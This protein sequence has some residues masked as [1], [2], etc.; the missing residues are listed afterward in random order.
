MVNRRWPWIILSPLITSTIT[1]IFFYII[2]GNHLL[3]LLKT[4]ISYGFIAGLAGASIGILASLPFR[5]VAFEIPSIIVGTIFS[6][7]GSVFGFLLYFFSHR[8]WG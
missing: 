6:F 1:A 4:S 8:F 7:M 2:V 5:K 3:E